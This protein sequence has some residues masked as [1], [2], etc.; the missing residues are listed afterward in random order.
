MSLREL[1]VVALAASAALGSARAEEPLT[2]ARAVERALAHDAEA[3]SAAAEVRAA[4]AR[5]DAA[6][7]P[8]ASNPE[9]SAGVGPRE[10]GG[11]R[12]VDFQVALSQRIE[13]GGQRGARVEAAR[14][15]VGA[16]E[17]RLSAT[18]ARVAAAVR[19]RVGRLAASRLRVRI[20]AQAR[21]L[22]DQAAGAAEK[23][24]QAGDVARVEVNS[25]RIERGR[26]ARAA[27]LAEEGAVTALAELE[28]L[29]G[30]EPG[31]SPE[32]SFDLEGAAGEAERDRDEAVREAL[33]SR[34]D[35]A[36]LR[37]TSPPRTPRRAWRRG[38]RRRPPRSASRSRGR[39]GRTSSSAPSRSTCRCSRA[40]RGARGVA[41]ARVEQARVA[42]AAL[43][44]RVAHEVRLGLERVG[45]A[46]RAVG[47]FDAATAAALDEHLALA[48]RAYE[49]GQLDFV[50]YLLLSREALEA[51]REQIDALEALNEARAQL[52]RALGRG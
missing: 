7:V 52:E 42:L 23:R 6:S 18:R 27:L 36:A 45:S 1:V 5:L 15:G 12:T 43:E 38:R 25:A 40:T 44:R 2:L 47:A 8:L 33:S 28:L 22:A 3:R 39:S 50:R 19:E 48:A 49:A 13:V 17:A 34:R 31:A 9:L 30:V 37:L 29:L 46:R 51:R 11:R 20:A 32:I 10:E 41:A 26:A 4:R 16:A 14:A 24:F 35:V 21:R